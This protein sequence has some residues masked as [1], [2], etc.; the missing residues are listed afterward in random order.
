M[1]DIIHLVCLWPLQSSNDAAWVVPIPAITSSSRLSRSTFSPTTLTTTYDRQDDG[2][3]FMCSWSDDDVHPSTSD[4]VTSRP[5]RRLLRR[6]VPWLRLRH[7]FVTMPTWRGRLA[8]AARRSK[9]F[10]GKP[11]WRSSRGVEVTGWCFKLVSFFCHCRI[12]LIH[13]YF[14]EIPSIAIPWPQI[15][16]PSMV[17]LLRGPC[18]EWS[19]VLWSDHH[20]QRLFSAPREIPTEQPP[21]L[22]AAGGESQGCAESIKLPCSQ[23]VIRML[24]VKPNQRCG[25]CIVF[26][27]QLSCHESGH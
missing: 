5:C 14:S 4:V 6:Q 26:R 7:H 18:L 13:I 20:W 25:V 17:R 9:G 3:H 23:T 16:Q 2:R 19:T 15:K 27:P 22:P 1:R 21:G 11:G 8:W 12:F 24:K 10:S